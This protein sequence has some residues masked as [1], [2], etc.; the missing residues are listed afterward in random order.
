ME[1]DKKE[2]TILLPS[3][4]VEQIQQIIRL[5]NALNSMRSK[6]HRQLTYDIEDFITGCV[7]KQLA[8][9]D[10]ARDLAKYEE[11]GN[12]RKLKNRIKEVAESKG[13]NQK[14][15]VEVTGINKGTM[16]TIFSNAHQPT[17][18]YLLRIW[19]ALGCPPLQ[20]LFYRE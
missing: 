18:D 3:K 16:S 4:T 20:E 13:W 8:H 9:I 6:E 12:A 11:L 19:I 17:S 10:M 14:G 5:E 7:N 1:N 2:I 15:L